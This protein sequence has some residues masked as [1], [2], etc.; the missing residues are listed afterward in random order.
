MCGKVPS[1]PELVACPKFPQV[2]NHARYSLHVLENGGIGDTVFVS[3]MGALSNDDEHL[4][5]IITAAIPILT[6]FSV[7]QAPHLPK[8]DAR[9]RD[10]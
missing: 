9:Y 2:A 4:I 5:S 10:R 8:V 1:V 3:A 6:F 7:Y